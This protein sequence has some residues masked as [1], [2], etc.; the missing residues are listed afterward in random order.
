MRIPRIK[1]RQFQKV[2]IKVAHIHPDYREGRVH[3]ND[4]AVMKLSRTIRS[5]RY[6]KQ[7]YLHLDEHLAT[8]HENISCNE[9]VRFY[10]YG[11]T[12]EMDDFHNEYWKKRLQV[13]ETRVKNNCVD[14]RNKNVADFII[15]NHEH[16]TTFYVSVC[17]ITY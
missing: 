4:I 11:K 5:S 9:T 15:T 17:N 16:R 3:R 2:T 8:A 10:G 6:A 12:F 1:Y 13:M 7:F 14:Y